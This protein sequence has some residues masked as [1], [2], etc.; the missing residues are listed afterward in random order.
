VLEVPP[1]RRVLQIGDDF[2]SQYR[3][4]AFQNAVFAVLVTKKRTNGR[5]NKRENTMPPP[6]SLA[7]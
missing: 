5:M 4:T 6:A 7:W 3:F 1:N 2:G